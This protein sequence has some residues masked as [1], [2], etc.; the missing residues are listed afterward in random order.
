MAR[1]L[2]DLLLVQEPAI[3][4]SRL[5]PFARVPTN[6]SLF[7]IIFFTA[8]ACCQFCLV[9]FLITQSF[10]RRKIFTHRLHSILV[11][12]EELRFYFVIEGC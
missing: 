11:V 6:S 7:I 2:E 10:S 5:S 12:S 8:A 4:G 9:E 3:T 1:L